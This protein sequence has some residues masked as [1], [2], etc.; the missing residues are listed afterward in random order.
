MCYIT[1]TELKNDLSYYMELSHK[2]DIYVTKNK[3]VITILT[4]PRS[5]NIKEFL[6][7][8]GILKDTDLKDKSYR[9]V[10]TEEKI[11]KCGY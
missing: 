2:E 11:K 5:R 6:D 1:A 8:G 9:D 3:K 10:I 4:S 7:L